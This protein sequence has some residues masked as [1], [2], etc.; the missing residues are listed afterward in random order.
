MIV[1]INA[2]PTLAEAEQFFENNIK[3]ST[4]NDGLLIKGGGILE[5]RESN[6][7][8]SELNPD[9]EKF[10]VV[11]YPRGTG[12]VIDAGAPTPEAA[13]TD[14]APASAPAS[15]GGTG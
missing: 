5:Y 6:I 10:A 11:S 12:V 2:F 7:P 14:S 1:I 13:N 9:A 4:T 8:K 15:P 3:N